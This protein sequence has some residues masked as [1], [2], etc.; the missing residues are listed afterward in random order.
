MV[1]SLSII[2]PAFN[3]ESSIAA[4]IRRTAAT[5]PEIKK[6]HGLDFVEIIVV[7]DGSSDKTFEI[8]R[9]EKG[10]SIITYEKNR[11]YGAAI[12]AGFRFSRGDIVG[13][14]DADGTCDPAFFIELCAPILRGEA[15]VVL[16]NRLNHG[17]KM[18]LVRKI[19][20]VLYARLLRFLTNN[21]VHD[22]ASGMRAI[23][24][25]ALSLLYP[26]PDGMDFTPAMSAK[27]LFDPD[28]CIKEISMPYLRRIGKSKLHVLKDGLK[29]LKI[30]LETAFA[31]R[32][33]LIYNIFTGMF[34]ACAFAYAYSPLAY[35]LRNRRIEDYMYYRLS[36]ITVM[37]IVAAITFNIG[38]IN[39]RITMLR[40]RKSL[41]QESFLAKFIGV[42]GVGFI[43]CALAITHKGLINYVLTGKVY[44]HWV[45]IL[46]GEF[47]SVL[48]LIFIFSKI[49]YST[50][51][52]IKKINCERPDA[53]VSL[54]AFEAQNR[55]TVVRTLTDETTP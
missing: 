25:E 41:V 42:W 22:T 49:I 32:P 37:L 55:C 20:N 51:N 43:A 3:E 54:K 10:V 16:G 33:L 38:L 28:V 39:Q 12:K 53:C 2:I 1:K 8:A 14:L 29:F 17:S 18:P 4:I 7:N 50:V 9:K 30:I 11:G 24:R 15:D 31:Y 26:L 40:D 52:F 13:F 36:A 6:I 21:V 45:Y 35:Y 47:L 5:A 19:G 27:A 46:T 48:G 23:K 34:A 44:L